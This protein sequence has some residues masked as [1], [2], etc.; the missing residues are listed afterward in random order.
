M[1]GLAY[2]LCISQYVTHSH[3]LAFYI[4]NMHLNNVPNMHI[5]L[6]CYLPL[7]SVPLCWKQ[8]LS[9]AGEQRRR[10]EAVFAGAPAFSRHKGMWF[11]HLSCEAIQ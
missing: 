5:Y 9:E 4:M 8:V 11:Q 1:G 2:D 3:A 7:A 10:G 6:L